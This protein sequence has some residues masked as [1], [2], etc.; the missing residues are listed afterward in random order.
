MVLIV[1]FLDWFYKKIL[2]LVKFDT[3]KLDEANRG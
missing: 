2:K 1:A 3:K